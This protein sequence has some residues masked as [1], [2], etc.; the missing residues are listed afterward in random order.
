[1]TVPDDVDDL[2]ACWL[3]LREEG[4]APDAA[5]F[6]AAHP[7]HGA[8]LQSA[9]EAL[10]A[11][12][13]VIPRQPALPDAV[14]RW[15][16]GKLLGTG[17]SGAVF[18][19]LDSTAPDRRAAVKILGPAQVNDPRAQARLRREARILM[20]DPHP[21][22]VRVLDVGPDG[23][24]PWLAMEV[25][26]GTSLR[27]ILDRARRRAADGNGPRC[28][29][30]QLPGAGDPWARVAR[31]GLELARA[32]A[33]AHDRGLV[34]RD[35]KPG[36]VMIRPDG[37]PVLLDF[38]LA[39]DTSATALT[40][41]GDILGTPA[42]MA[43]EQARGERAGPAADVYGLGAILYEMLT[44]RAPFEGPDASTILRRVRTSLPTRPGRVDP[45][46]PAPLA[47]IVDSAMA[48]RAAWRPEGP[49]AL[50]E[51]L[52]RFLAGSPV[53]ARPPRAAARLLW[54]ASA[55]PL[56]LLSIAGAALLVIAVA[57]ILAHQAGE[58]RRAQ[59]LA[60]ATGRAA[61]ILVEPLGLQGLEA[62]AS[63]IAVLGR[64]PDLG[65]LLA[66]IAASRVPATATDAAVKRLV[67]AERAR[68][69]G[70]RREARRLLEDAVRDAPESAIAWALLARLAR[71]D[72]E[73]ARLCS[74][75]EKASE[76]EPRRPELQAGLAH[77]LLAEGDPDGAARAFAAASAAANDHGELPFHEARALEA[78]SRPVDALAA[79]RRGGVA[80]LLRYGR[81]LDRT[82][83]GERAR[84]AYREALALE[85]DR[86]D[87][88]FHL[89]TSLSAAEEVAAA[90]DEY[91]EILRR[92]PDHAPSLVSLAWLHAW[93]CGHER[94]AAV[95]DPARAIELAC[96]AVRTDAGR[97]RAILT[98]ATRIARHLDRREPLRLAI[99]DVLRSLAPGTSEASLLEDAL[100]ELAAGR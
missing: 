9:I 51:D 31:C 58:R 27:E 16:L 91:R 60:S 50:A 43:P 2:V 49:R 59:A 98:T 86:I 35:L 90:A 15:R 68:A 53:A 25:V 97:E 61:M 20:Q 87:A 63:E 77:L 30:L 45:S 36:N 38:G 28:S 99:E 5:V 23:P 48:P 76:R 93:V 12:E 89:A 6:A 44:L 95:R 29:L 96:A 64:S 94:C 46:V 71:D 100:R 79:A 17:G 80:A 42:Y 73:R 26:D 24:I 18:E 55:R 54:H 14:G 65:A 56:L 70:D 7:G 85:P 81:V 37:R 39:A 34:H 88:R 57:A 4:R 8:A 83:R 22:V 72:P 52:E 32:L 19:A 69:H 40:R 84:A 67:E 13:G 78:C 82:Q 3:A 1:M 66:D 75:L 11:T 10:L 21:N 47:A 41:S 33:W 62:A 92:K 74:L